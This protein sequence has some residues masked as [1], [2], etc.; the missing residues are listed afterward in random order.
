MIFHFRLIPRKK[1]EKIFQKLQKNPPLLAHICHNLPIFGQNRIL[2]T[3]LFLSI[4]LILNKYLFEWIPTN[5]FLGRTHAR[6]DRQ[7]SINLQEFCRYGLG[8]SKSIKSLHLQEL[9]FI[10]LDYFK[11]FDL[12]YNQVKKYLLKCYHKTLQRCKW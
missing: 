4:F 2:F 11:L 12:N 7:T 6:T 3:K 1:N 8:S 9:S 5:I 10:S